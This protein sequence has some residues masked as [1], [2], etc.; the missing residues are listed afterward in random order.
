MTLHHTLVDPEGNAARGW[1]LFLHGIMGTGANW[2]TIA[3][4]LVAA[5][6]DLGA[7]LVDLRMHGRSQQAAP[8]HT[9]AAA[10]ADLGE[11]AA[12]LAAAGRPVVAV[13]AHSFGGKVALAWRASR[14]SG[15]RDTWVMDASPAARPPDEGAGS[16]LRVLD[17]LAS[18]PP[19]FAARDA[20]IAALGE[21]GVSRPVGEWLAMNLE[22]DGDDFTLRLDVA[23]LR[24]LLTDYYATDLWDAAL[25]DALPGAVNVVIA[26]RS[27]AIA[28]EDRARLDAAGPPVR[29]HRLDTGH[30][31][32]LEAPAAVV[33][34]L[35][36]GLAT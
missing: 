19:R 14:P 7:V 5:R 8:P 34:L 30:W 15:L 29:V 1:V 32:H 11:L 17:A 33:E 9:V 26:E 21:R 6:P 35:V 28:P 36:T 2:R 20:F 18:L 31:L 27:S 13:V 23:A 4:K 25:S 12:E 16:P 24:A 10:A 22:P 3:R